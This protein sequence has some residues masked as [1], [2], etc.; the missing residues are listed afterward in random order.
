ML[1]IPRM[2]TTRGGGAIGHDKGG[3]I[4]DDDSSESFILG[5]NSTAREENAVYAISGG[6]TP[7]GFEMFE[8]RQ[9]GFTRWMN[10]QRK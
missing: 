7:T 10:T 1:K 4:A 2:G 5:S 6:K 8:W 3:G 9:S